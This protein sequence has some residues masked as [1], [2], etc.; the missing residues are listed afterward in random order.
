M[1]DVLNRP[2]SGPEPRARERSTSMTTEQTG[3]L[4][5]KDEAGHYFLVAQETL[6]RARV[7]AEHKAELERLL[8]EPGADASGYMV[9]TTYTLFRVLNAGAKAIGDFTADAA[10]VQWLEQQLMSGGPA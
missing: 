5:L 7:P 1:L 4:V 10:L 9:S 6:E 2:S 8:T 3:T